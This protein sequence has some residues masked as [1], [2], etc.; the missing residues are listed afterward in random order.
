[1]QSLRW[2]DISSDAQR[3]VRPHAAN[4]WQHRYSSPTRTLLPGGKTC[5]DDCEGISFRYTVGP[6]VTEFTTLI[7]IP[8]DIWIGVTPFGGIF[9]QDLSGIAAQKYN[10]SG[11]RRRVPAERP[12][13]M[14]Y[15]SPFNAE[16]GG[17]T[18]SAPDSRNAKVTVR[19]ARRR[20]T[21]Q[22]E[23]IRPAFRIWNAMFDHPT[24]RPLPMIEREAVT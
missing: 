15:L 5:E 6:E 20:N 1:M 21:I 16:I 3:N 19:A 17:G 24:I 12:I 23:D 22:K 10:L 4:T 9:G 7:T 13:R 14:P 11:E 18:G 8:G 2:R